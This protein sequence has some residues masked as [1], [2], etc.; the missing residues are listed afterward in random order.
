[1]TD[2]TT[3]ST[4]LNMLLKFRRKFKFKTKKQMIISLLPISIRASIL[5]QLLLYKVSIF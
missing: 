2:N 4:S 1:M 3:K 5:I